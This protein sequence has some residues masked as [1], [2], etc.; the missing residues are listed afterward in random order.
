MRLAGD[1]ML[2]KQCSGVAAQAWLTILAFMQM[3]LQG[4][5]QNATLGCILGNEFC[6][7]E[8]QIDFHLLCFQ[9]ISSDTDF[10]MMTDF[11]LFCLSYLTSDPPC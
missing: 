9:R 1:E 3:C 2:G 4:K 5:G 8:S 7:W 6:S 11:A 10:L